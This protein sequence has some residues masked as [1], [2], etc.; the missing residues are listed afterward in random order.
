MKNSYGL[1]VVSYYEPNSIHEE[2]TIAV[3]NNIE[4]AKKCKGYYSKLYS[5]CYIDKINTVYSTFEEELE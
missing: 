3:F 5:H 2:V 1:F 4:A